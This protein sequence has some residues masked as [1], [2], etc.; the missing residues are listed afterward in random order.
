MTHAFVSYSWDSD[1][2]KAW[3]RNLAEKLHAGGIQTTLDQWSTVPGDNL[4]L[5]METAIRENPYVIVV[6][7]PRYKL[8]SDKRD[9]GTGYEGDIMTGEVFVL[10]NRRKFIPVLRAGEWREAAPSW[11]L[12]SYYVDLRGEQS[13]STISLLLD[14]LHR[15][16]PDPPPVQAQGFLALQS[17]DVL[18]NTTGLIWTNCRKT[19]FVE[20]D[21]VP[22]LLLE[23][24]Q[25]TG[26]HWRLP[27]NEEV[28]KVKSAEEYYARP[29][30]MVIVEGSR[31][32]L[33]SFHKSAWTPTIR[34]N[35]TS[36]DT[37]KREG[38]LNR[39]YGAFSGMAEVEYLRRRFPI[40]F[41]REA[42]EEDRQSIIAPS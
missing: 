18:D 3:V 17:G 12:G 24:N 40:R 15:R 1:E 21:K 4:P 9:G 2:H 13:T 36:G 5:F 39:F 20:Y 37:A 26:Y 16:L 31:P 30:I 19:D 25:A 33:G 32:L 10:K 27:S 22:A 14:T 11:L 29:P 34:D 28:A 41:V 23:T 38:G 35:C 42:N 7:T 6:C 8:K